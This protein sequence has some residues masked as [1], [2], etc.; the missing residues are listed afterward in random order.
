MAAVAA[1]TWIN[2]FLSKTLEA[3]LPCAGFFIVPAH[4]LGLHKRH[5]RGRGHNVFQHKLGGEAQA[6]FRPFHHLNGYEQDGMSCNALLSFAF[7]HGLGLFA[8]L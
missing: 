7:R 2:Q 8:R 4:S 3:A 5:L 1:D 6:K